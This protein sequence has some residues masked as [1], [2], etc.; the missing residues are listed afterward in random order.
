MG[1]LDIFKK[2]QVKRTSVKR[3]KKSDEKEELLE[4]ADKY[5]EHFINLNK[6]IEELI[7]R[8]ILNVVQNHDEF[9]ELKI[10]AKIAAHNI[11]EE[12][13]NLLPE[14]LIGKIGKPDRLKGKYEN[15]GEWPMVVENSVLMII[16][17]YKE[18]G[19]DIL[20]KI[21]YGNTTLKLKAINLL[22]KLATEGVY[23]ENI[24]DDIMNNII[25]FNDNDKI[26]I[27]GFASQIKENNKIIA[28][29]QH[30]YKEFLKDEDVE[31]AYKTLVHL[32]NAAQ[33]C[34]TG[35]LN[36]L[37]FIA[38]DSDK[39][40]LK[41]VIDVKAGDKDFIEVININEFTKIRAALTFYNIN[42]QDEDINNSLIYWCENY[43][44]DEVKNEIKRL[45]E[46]KKLLT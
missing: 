35:H 14:Y 44:D 23:T 26:V 16:F 45:F 42:Q 12:H 29:I 38:M 33:R 11:G 32:I 27:L 39:I 10:R 19:V 15:L 20:T 31:S 17:S 5:N 25:K 36:F 24:V 7:I 30:F 40:D 21:A 1:I 8:E 28:L 22:V 37:K 3:E 18:K 13:I 9:Q 41:K 2:K 46:S 34:T 4:K 43:K 6:K